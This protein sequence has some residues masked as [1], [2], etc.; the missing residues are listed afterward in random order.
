MAIADRPRM[1]RTSFALLLSLGLAALAG[2]SAEKELNMGAVVVMTPVKPPAA[3]AG[4]DPGFTAAVGAYARQVMGLRDLGPE[5]TD[6]EIRSALERLA[7]AVEV[8]PGRSG[9]GAPSAAQQIRTDAGLM[10]FGL[11]LGPEGTRPVVHALEVSAAALGELARG[12]YKAEPAVQARVA[13][14]H[15]AV[16][17]LRASDD[18]IRPPRAEVI[19]TLEQ[20][21]LVLTAM[22]A[23]ARRLPAQE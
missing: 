10:M 12:P 2:C 5:A 20:A 17:R 22:H 6:A 3:H 16:A 23:A 13:G 19:A 21:A 4:V 18:A 14:L 11:R 7:D 15:Q 8:A 9:P 1:V